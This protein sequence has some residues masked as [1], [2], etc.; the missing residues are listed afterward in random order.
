[1][2]LRQNDLRFDVADDDE[3]GIVGRIPIV[4]EFAQVGTGGFVKR[5]A[6]AEC[7]V[8]VRRAFEHRLQKLHVKKV[9]GI[10]QILRHF[11]LDRAAFLRP[12]RFVRQ[13]ILHPRRLDAECD[14]QIFGGRGEKILCDGLLRVG[15]VV[16]AKRGGNRR[17]L[18]G[19]QTGAAAKHH[20]LG[21]VR[22]AGKPSG[23]FIRADAIIHHRRDDGR[24][25]ITH[26]DDL[27]SVRQRGAKNVLFGSCGIRRINFSAEQ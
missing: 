20:V 12:K 7:V 25:G 9:S 24:D 10:R 22:G 21:R 27:Q 2:H 13:Q 23:R 16:A 6:R 15:V 5:W 4:V 1:M 26:N 18:V 17:K 19:A 11:L 14:F 8:F 3:H